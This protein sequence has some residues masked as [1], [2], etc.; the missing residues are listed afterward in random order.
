MESRD[1]EVHRRNWCQFLREVRKWGMLGTGHLG[2][3]IKEDHLWRLLICHFGGGVYPWL[4]G[5][6]I[7]ATCP[8][9][10]QKIVKKQTWTNATVA[11]GRRK[12]NPS[13][14]EM[15]FCHSPGCF[16]RYS[17]HRLC[18]KFLWSRRLTSIRSLR[19]VTWQ[20]NSSWRVFGPPGK[21]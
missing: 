6:S 7:A 8:V 5:I 21:V 19:N 15:W 17:Q 12:W 2:L 13:Q 14:K 11:N 10:L 3:S 20:I 18:Q 9:S 16:T 1:L 4:S